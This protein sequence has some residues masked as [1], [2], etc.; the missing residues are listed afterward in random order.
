M[1]VGHTFTSGDDTRRGAGALLGTDTRDDAA[2]ATR[3]VATDNLDIRYPATSFSPS[4]RELSLPRAYHGCISRSYNSISVI[5][6]GRYVVIV[7]SW[8]QRVFA[9]V[10]RALPGTSVSSYR[11]FFRTRYRGC[12]RRLCDPRSTVLARSRPI[13]LA[14]RSKAASFVGLFQHFAS[15]LPITRRRRRRDTQADNLDG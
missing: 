14:A 7:H 15:T 11:A 10:S 13:P 2:A 3:T 12:F 1:Q 8:P 6:S 9:R 4:K 5:N